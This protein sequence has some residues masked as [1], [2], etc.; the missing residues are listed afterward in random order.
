MVE[1]WD[2]PLRILHWALAA[3][4]PIAWFTANVLD[5]VHEVAGYAALALVAFRLVWGFVGPLHARFASFVRA[6]GIVLRYL[7]RLAHGRTD[8][9]LGHNPGGAAMTVTLLLLVAVSSVSGWMQVTERFFG[10]DWV[11][12]VHTYS[13]HL[14]LIMAIVH[15]IGVLLMCILQRQNLMLA[16][17]TGRKRARHGSGKR[18]PVDKS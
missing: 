10:I 18:K 8:Y 11:E 16:M 9:Y 4:V 12:V 2:L 1:V 17:I 3:S 13:S 15:L 6:P 7:R 14:L 5:T